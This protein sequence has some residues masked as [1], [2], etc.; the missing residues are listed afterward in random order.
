[1]HEALFGD[2]IIAYNEVSRLPGKGQACIK[3]LGLMAVQ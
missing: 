1:M 2:G 3:E